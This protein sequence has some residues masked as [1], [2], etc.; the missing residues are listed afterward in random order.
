MLAS[1]DSGVRPPVRL[2]GLD[3]QYALKCQVRVGKSDETR[4][5]SVVTS[6]NGSAHDERYFL[7]VMSALLD[8]V[9][10]TPSLDDLAH[11]ITELAGIFQRLS[12]PSRESVTGLAGELV[13]IAVASDPVAAAA[14]WRT[15][16]DDRYDFSA[17]RLRLEVKSTATRKRVHSFSYEQSDVPAGCQ[18][19]VASLFIERSAGGTTLEDLI[20][21]IASRLVSSPATIFR[22]EQVLAS[23]LGSSLPEALSFAFDMELARSELAFF[24]LREIPAIRSLPPSVSQVRFASDLSTT[25]K[26][27][28]GDFSGLCPAITAFVAISA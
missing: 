19:V 6:T 1:L 10:P 5:L 22:V 14:A 7:H 26:L 4:V 25:S 3:A 17:D 8:L 20:L 11:A 28:I 23:T 27:D 12:S 21:I 13:L 15:D 18:G 24:D 2:G 16:P 9:G